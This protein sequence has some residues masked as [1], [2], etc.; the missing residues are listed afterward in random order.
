MPASRTSPDAS[1]EAK[2]FPIADRFFR[3]HEHPKLD[4]LAD[5]TGSLM[6]CA[7]HRVL[8]VHFGS[9]GRP[10]M[11]GV[12]R[13]G[14][15]AGFIGDEP[16]ESPMSSSIL[17]ALSG[18]ISLAS[19][20]ELTIVSPNHGMDVDVNGLGADVA[21]AGLTPASAT[22]YINGEPDHEGTAT[23]A[24]TFAD[25]VGVAILPEDSRPWAPTSCSTT[26]PATT[27]PPGPTTAPAC[28]A[29]CAST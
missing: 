13:E 28:S 3:V 2:T 9:S 10:Y 25:S 22:V 26:T 5:R 16:P 24:G 14:A 21:I 12:P 19:A 7:Q 15:V 11:N 18:V 29:P 1:P 23:A 20:A 27:T 8:L 4:V 6:T 17:F